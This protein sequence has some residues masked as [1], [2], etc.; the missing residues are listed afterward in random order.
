VKFMWPQYGTDNIGVYTS[1]TGDDNGSNGIW[2]VEKYWFS[3]GEFP[4]LKMKPK[5]GLGCN[6]GIPQAK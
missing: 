5:R 2:N 6:G 4:L 3:S 1:K